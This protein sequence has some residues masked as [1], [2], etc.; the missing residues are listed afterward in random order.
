MKIKDT[1]QNEAVKRLISKKLNIFKRQAITIER[2]KQ[3]I[4]NQKK[5]LHSLALEYV[6][7]GD[8]ALAIEE[9]GVV[10]EGSVTYGKPLDDI[11]IRSALANY[12]KALRIMPE[13]IDAMI[14][15]A[16]LLIAI[17]QLDGAEQELT[18]A[19]ELEKNNYRAHMT[20]GELMELNHDIPEAIKSYKRA[21]KAD[22]KQPQPHDR[23]AAIYERIGFDDLAEDEQEIADRL[24]RAL[25]KAKSKKKKK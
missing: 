7:M 13:C 17:D 15:K 23:L 25:Y 11:A 18:K 4:E 2:L 6:S 16:R 21:A 9:S 12:N 3:V 24:R 20:M 8:Q 5:T 19:L 22:K 10:E 1:L 14:G